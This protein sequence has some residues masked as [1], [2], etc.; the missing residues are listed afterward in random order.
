MTAGKTLPVTQAHLARVRAVPVSDMHVGVDQPLRLIVVDGKGPNGRRPHLVTLYQHAL[1]YDVGSSV[2]RFTG[3]V[4]EAHLFRTD[5]EP[6]RIA[7]DPGIACCELW[8][9][10]KTRV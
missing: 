9:A 1:G 7:R 5:R 10:M 4:L 8:I 2:E 6:P 3:V